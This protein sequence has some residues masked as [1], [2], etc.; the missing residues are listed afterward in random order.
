MRTAVKLTSRYAWE[1]LLQQYPVGGVLDRRRRDPCRHTARG[2]ARL[3]Y[4]NGQ[5]TSAQTGKVLN[6]SAGGILLQLPE[7]VR[8]GRLVVLRL[9]LGENRAILVGRVIHCTPAADGFKIGVELLFD[10]SRA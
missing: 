2:K 8:T 7:R 9:A 3:I 10:D 5:E 6:V 4:R 1:H